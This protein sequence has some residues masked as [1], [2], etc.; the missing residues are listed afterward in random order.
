M[1]KLLELEKK[2]REAREELMKQAPAAMGADLSGADEMVNTAKSE[3]KKPLKG[4]QSELDQ[5]KDGDIEADDLAALREKKKSMKK[6]GDLNKIMSSSSSAPGSVNTTGGPSIASQIGFGKT[7][8][9]NLEHHIKYSVRRYGTVAPS[10]EDI[11]SGGRAALF[12]I[13][14]LSPEDSKVSPHNKIGSVQTNA[15][16]EV[17]DSEFHPDHSHISEKIHDYIQNNHSKLVKSI[18]KKAEHPDEKEDKELIAE[19]LDRHNEK[20]HGEAKD[21]D[22]AKKD[23]GLKKSEEELV[24]LPN[25]QWVLTKSRKAPSQEDRMDGSIVKSPSTLVGKGTGRIRMDSLRAKTGNPEDMMIRAEEQAEK[26]K[27]AKKKKT[28]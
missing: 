16:G 8:T 2:L 12:H 10:R 3:D 23:M 20:K 15:D 26:A 28:P 19:A 17:E 11:S 7:D 4:R 1:K 22:S 18:V 21:K 24:S 13:H 9:K 5:D 6:S 14:A 27:K 25:G